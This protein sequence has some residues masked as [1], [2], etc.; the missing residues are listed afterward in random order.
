MT[1]VEYWQGVDAL[2]ESA[3]HLCLFACCV[4]MIALGYIGGRQR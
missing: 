4:T 3:W 1:A 2:I